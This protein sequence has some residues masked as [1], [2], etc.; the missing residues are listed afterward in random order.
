MQ[1]GI[2]SF[3]KT[4]EGITEIVLSFVSHEILCS[5]SIGSRLFPIMVSN[6]LA[7]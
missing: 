1:E 3:G 5:M 7:A 2:W 4:G 6:R